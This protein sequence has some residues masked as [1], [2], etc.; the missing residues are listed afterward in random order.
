MTA[1]NVIYIALHINGT[2]QYHNVQAYETVVLDFMIS[3]RNLMT[4]SLDETL[5]T[6]FVCIATCHLKN[7]TVGF[8]ENL[9]SQSRLVHNVPDIPGLLRHFRQPSPQH[10]KVAG[11]YLAFSG[12]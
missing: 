5:L 1:L 12:S 10:V 4:A 9:P 2:M 7:A 11:F 3:P 8:N 6:S